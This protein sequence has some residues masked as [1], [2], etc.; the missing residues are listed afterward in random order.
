MPAK[1]KN[2]NCTNDALTEFDEFEDDMKT[3]LR[4]LEGGYLLTPAVIPEYYPDPVG[5]FVPMQLRSSVLLALTRGK[6]IVASRLSIAT[7]PR[8]ASTPRML[9]ALT[10]FAPNIALCVIVLS[11]DSKITSIIAA[12]P[13]ARFENSSQV[14]LLVLLLMKFSCVPSMVSKL[15]SSPTNL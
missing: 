12:L 4:A 8:K 11:Q 10:L 2:W 7:I 13:T 6:Q 14:L 9:P 1:V 5:A 3:D 15:N